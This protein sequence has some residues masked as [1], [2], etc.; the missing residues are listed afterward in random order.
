MT[1]QHWK[2][3]LQSQLHIITRGLHADAMS[4]RAAAVRARRDVT[5]HLE[6][7]P[8]DVVSRASE[9]IESEVDDLLQE[10]MARNTRAEEYAQERETLAD[11]AERRHREAHARELLLERHLRRTNE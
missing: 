8:L 6:S 7:D 4:A 1:I 11:S 10:W 2:E 5:L 9:R 3:R